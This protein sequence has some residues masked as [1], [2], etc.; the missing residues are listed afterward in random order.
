MA[1]LLLLPFAD[2]ADALR[3]T[4]STENET[5]ANEAA[6]E[7][8]DGGAAKGPGK[9]LLFGVAGGALVAGAAAGWL[10]LGPKFA[11]AP[12]AAA[13]HA[14]PGAEAHGDAA[15]E[16]G[17]E[18]RLE[19]LI[20]NPAGSQGARFL[21]A[22]VVLQVSEAAEAKLK[23]QEARLRDTISEILGSATLE[24]ITAPDARAQMK[25]RIGAVVRPVVGDAERVAIYFPQFVV[26]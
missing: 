15:T 14:A 25:T 6:A 10:V 20:V 8:Q 24:Q 19:S 3:L 22:T 26:Q 12:A 21:M 7:Q 4:T 11:P 13:E 18:F 2:T 17:K 9:G 23:A 16:K 5:M 1:H